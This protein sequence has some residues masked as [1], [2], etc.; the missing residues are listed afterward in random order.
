MGGWV[1]E[2][3]ETVRFVSLTQINK[4]IF[5]EILQRRNNGWN[6]LQT[7]NHR[8][9]VHI[10]FSTQ[11]VRLIP[12]LIIFGIW[13]LHAQRGTCIIILISRFLI[14]AAYLRRP[15]W[16]IAGLAVL[17]ANTAWRTRLIHRI[18]S[19]GR[20]G[21]WQILNSSSP[22]TGIKLKLPWPWPHCE[23]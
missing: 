10:D 20:R 21:R 7:E 22:L 1:N 5:R 16:L 23:V 4:L 8:D 2:W 17:N 12:V 15:L 14:I 13:C 11:V 3:M 6:N 19:E 9:S 18:L